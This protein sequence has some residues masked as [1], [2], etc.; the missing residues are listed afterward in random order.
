MRKI[1]WRFSYRATIEAL[2]R[3]SKK[4]SIPQ[5]EEI[6]VAS[7]KEAQKTLLVNMA[8]GEICENGMRSQFW[9][10]ILE[11]LEDLS[12]KKLEKFKTTDMP[13]ETFLAIQEVMREI[14][15][16]PQKVV[17]IA[18]DSERQLNELEETLR[19]NGFKQKQEEE[20]DTESV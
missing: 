2:R 1:N 5:E 17:I 10:M 6:N 18:K 13:K 8:Q 9:E 12:A 15:E 16:Y 7:V 11:Y 3:K 19:E 4:P 14:A 20:D